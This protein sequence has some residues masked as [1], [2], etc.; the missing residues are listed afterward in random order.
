MKTNDTSKPYIKPEL[1]ACCGAR[2]ICDNDLV[3]VGTGFPATSANIAKH[4]HAPNAVMMQETVGRCWPLSLGRASHVPHAPIK[5]RLRKLPVR[6]TRN[7]RV[8]ACTEMRTFS[9]RLKTP[10]NQPEGCVAAVAR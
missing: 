8:S 10:P 2:E 9:A 4:M 6:A 7:E 1:M 3:I 5:C